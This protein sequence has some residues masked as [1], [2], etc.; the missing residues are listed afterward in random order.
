MY[1]D[2]INLC[3][4]LIF[5]IVVLYVYCLLTHRNAI[6]G[7]SQIH[8]CKYF[9]SCETNLYDSD[10]FKSEVTDIL[11]HIPN[12][13]FT[14]VSNIDDAQIKIALV[15]R[16]ALDKFHDSDPKIRYSI[17]AF[18]P[19]YKIPTSMIDVQNY[20][21]G[22]DVSKF[23]VADYKKYVIIHEVLHAIG[24]D[25]VECESNTK[26]NVMH[27]HT[28]GI[29]DSSEP[30]YTV[31]IQQLQSMPRLSNHPYINVFTF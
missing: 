9:I 28:R 26:C 5:C 6:T 24:F 14:P 11:K 13:N 25:H 4:L 19:E 31:S 17:T 20:K 21:N 23:S 22:V 27:Q 18:G 10:A 8:T 1:Q 30:N 12:V 15:D 2:I 16:Q 29:P 7:G 3:C